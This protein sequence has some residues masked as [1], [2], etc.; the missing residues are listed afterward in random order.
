MLRNVF[1]RN[2]YESLRWSLGIYDYVVSEGR[3][4]YGDTKISTQTK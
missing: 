2:I 4:K 3:G 1:E